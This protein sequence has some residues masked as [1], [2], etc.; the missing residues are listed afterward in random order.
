MHSPEPDKGA[1][2]MDVRAVVCTMKELSSPNTVAHEEEAPKPPKLGWFAALFSK[3]NKEVRPTQGPPPDVADA[4]PEDNTRAAPPHGPDDVM[5]LSNGEPPQPR[6]EKSLDLDT[7]TSM[8]AGANGGGS[9]QG[10]GGHNPI[11]AP[12]HETSS[13]AWG[14]YLAA[15]PSQAHVHKGPCSRLSQRSIAVVEDESS[16]GGWFLNLFRRKKN[17]SFTAPSAEASAGEPKPRR[18]KRGGGGGGGSVARVSEPKPR[19]SKRG[20]GGSGSGGNRARTSRG[21]SNGP[22]PSQLSVASWD[23]LN[24]PAHGSLSNIPGARSSA[25]SSMGGALALRSSA[26]IFPAPTAWRALLWPERWTHEAQQQYSQRRSTAGSSLSRTLALQSSAGSEKYTPGDLNHVRASALARPSGTSWRPSAN[27]AGPASTVGEFTSGPIGRI[28]KRIASKHVQAQNETGWDQYPHIGKVVNG[29]KKKSNGAGSLAS[30]PIGR[31]A[32]RIANKHVQAQN[33]TGWDQYPH[34]GKVVNG[35]K[36]KSD[37]AGSLARYSQSGRSSRAASATSSVNTSLAHIPQPILTSGTYRRASRGQPPPPPGYYQPPPPG[38]G[39]PP[40]YA[41]PP[42]GGAHGGPV[43]ESRGGASNPMQA[44]SP[45]SWDYEVGVQGA[46]MARVRRALGWYGKEITE[47]LEF[48]IQAA[49]EQLH[50]QELPGSYY[51]SEYSESGSEDEGE[52]SGPPQAAEV[53]DGGA[54]WLSRGL[55]GTWRQYLNPA[56]SLTPGPATTGELAP[57]TANSSP[58]IT[59]PG[60]PPGPLGEGTLHEDDPALFPPQPVSAMPSAHPQAGRGPASTSTQGA[61]TRE[62]SPPSGRTS[63]DVFTRTPAELSSQNPASPS[64]PGP[65]AVA[66]AIDGE[67]GDDGVDYGDFQVDAKSSQRYAGNR[68]TSDNTRLAATQANARRAAELAAKAKREADTARAKREENAAAMKQ[69]WATGPLQGSS[70]ETAAPK[71]GSANPPGVGD[72]ASSSKGG[73]NKRGKDEAM[74]DAFSDLLSFARSS[75]IVGSTARPGGTSAKKSD[76][77]SELDLLKL[78]DLRGGAV[79]KVTL[80]SFMDLSSP[81]PKRARGGSAANSLRDSKGATQ[82]AAADLIAMMQNELASSGRQA[83]VAAARLASTKVDANPTQGSNSA[84]ASSKLSKTVT[85]E[86][87]VE[88]ALASMGVPARASSKTASATGRVGPENQVPSQLPSKNSWMTDDAQAAVVLSTPSSALSPRATDDLAAPAGQG[89]FQAGPGSP[90]DDDADLALPP[91]V[92]TVEREKSEAEKRHDFV[93]MKVEERFS[94]MFCDVRQL[95]FLMIAFFLAMVIR[96]VLVGLLIGIQEGARVVPGTGASQGLNILLLLVNALFLAF[97]VVV[98]P[99]RTWFRF[100]LYA[101]LSLLECVVCGFIVYLT[102]TA[103]ST[104]AQDSMFYTQIAL[105]ALQTIVTWVT[106]TFLAIEGYNRWRHKQVLN[107]FLDLTDVRLLQTEFKVMKSFSRQNSLANQK[108]SFTDEHEKPVVISPEEH[109]DA[110][111]AAIKQGQ[112]EARML[113]ERLHGGDSLALPGS[114]LDDF[115]KHV[116]TTNA[117]PMAA[118][119]EKDALGKDVPM[120]AELSEGNF[121]SGRMKLVP[122]A[123]RPSSPAIHREGAPKPVSPANQKQ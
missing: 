23:S 95:S 37:G 59:A 115:D 113:L 109:E 52:S 36:K 43:S 33:E 18:S 98:R 87:E 25:G 81:P 71:P 60:A 9:G 112:L 103:G 39:P 110:L 106:V 84:R 122:T 55:L 61:S 28:A 26:A 89:V 104:T 85:K 74:D 118:T 22:T 97:L 2:S 78:M 91:V 86:D 117:G 20:G 92:V 54:S 7:I 96:N 108:A 68:G 14:E 62:A 30:G 24:L 17:P 67:D 57:H 72:G 114:A 64:S 66:E 45:S 3:K 90:S 58:S 38:Y 16:K 42:A 88:K 69:A 93:R 80:D 15:T 101:L 19:Q 116:P 56:F 123:P 94:V 35:K 32:K 44:N 70:S 50:G 21:R 11:P 105:I 4:K 48:G 31:I 82:D 120:R 27:G 46:D 100:S 6:S 51:P 29:K 5:R 41:P 76:L 111:H 102:F 83:S 47:V 1:E 77:D 53:N 10:S 34:I 119:N 107:R 49:S 13:T 8:L 99:H 75:V 121:G 40:G 63:I 73:G 12:A 65:R 79:P